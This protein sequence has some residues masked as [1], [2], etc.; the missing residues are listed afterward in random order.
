VYGPAEGR[1]TRVAELALERRES[2]TSSLFPG[3][4]LPLSDIFDA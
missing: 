4:D 3:L 2:L 1:Y